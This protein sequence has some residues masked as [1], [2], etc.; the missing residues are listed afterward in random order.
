MFYAYIQHFMDKIINEK[1]IS[2]GFFLNGNELPLTKPVHAIA[3]T[4]TY[5]SSVLGGRY[6]LNQFKIPPFKMNFL[7][8]LH[9]LILTIISFFLFVLI[10]GQVIPIIQ[11]Q[12]FFFSICN[13]EAWENN[14]VF[15]Y[16][17]NYLLKYYEFFD[18]IFLVFKQKK[19]TFLHTYHHGATALLCYIQLIG[20]TTISWLPISLN[21]F[22]HILMYFY[23][24]LV[25]RGIKV[26]W[27]KLVTRFQIAQFII[28]LGFICFAFYQKIIYK[29]NLKYETKIPVYGD[30]A[31]RMFAAYFG[32]AILSSYL[33]LFTIFYKNVYRK[34]HLK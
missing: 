14:L 11:K 23:Y 28:D 4:M 33:L 8:Q 20:Q 18:T 10:I 30:C 9:N 29:Y 3:V 12:G 26:T 22:I 32:I 16:Y 17:L 13:T 21:L 24:F 19:L 7:F 31:G 15:F 25:S 5:Y 2:T 34:T 27:K 1:I 6:L